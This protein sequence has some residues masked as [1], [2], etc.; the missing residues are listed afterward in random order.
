MAQNKFGVLDA[1]GH[2]VLFA[3]ANWRSAFGALTLVAVTTGAT[4]AAPY[5][6]APQ[7]TLPA[8]VASA[9]AGCVAYGALYRRAFAHEH[10]GDS[11]FR[12]GPGGL[13]WGKP[14][15]RL[16]G[17]GAYLLAV[18]A[19]L[20]LATFAVMVA[21]VF[22]GGGGPVLQ[23]L[24][25]SASPEAV[26]EALM[27]VLPAQSSALLSLVV[28]V[29]LVLVFWL[30]IRLSLYQ[31]AV[32][33]EERVVLFRSWTL[34]KGRFWL[35]FASTVLVS[36]PSLTASAVTTAVERALG[37]PGAN[38]APVLPLGAVLA[39]SVLTAV[40]AGYVQLPLATGLY[41]ELYRRLRSDAAQ[42]G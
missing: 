35:V 8:V 18:M 30:G 25:P 32:V 38:G 42:R 24:S 11:G 28:L 19:A 15:W 40:V 4:M 6:G 13:Q 12:T 26:S 3:K 1:V 7:L 20:M 21:I 22:A 16:L 5:L 37:M 33:A 23:S 31:A 41:A 34:T 36:L 29:F 17:A 27:K 10:P 14:E 2:A 39:V 9:L